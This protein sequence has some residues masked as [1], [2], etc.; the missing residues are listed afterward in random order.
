MLASWSTLSIFLRLKMMYS[1]GET[2]PSSSASITCRGM[3]RVR[4]RRSRSSGARALAPKRERCTCAAGVGHLVESLRYVPLRTV[5]YRYVPLHTM[6]HLVE[7][8]R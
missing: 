8:L 5:T 7:L 3:L 4:L 1:S 2:T 6:A